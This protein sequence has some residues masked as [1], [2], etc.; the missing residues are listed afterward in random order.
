MQINRMQLIIMRSSAEASGIPAFF[1]KVTDFVI[2]VTE[3]TQFRGSFSHR[4]TTSA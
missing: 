3:M 2:S 4:F 1:Q